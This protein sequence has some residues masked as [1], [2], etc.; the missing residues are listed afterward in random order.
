M[1]HTVYAHVAFPLSPCW[2]VVWTLVL[3][4]TLHTLI[5]VHY[6]FTNGHRMIN[7]YSE[8]L[9]FELAVGRCSSEVCLITTMCIGI[10]LFRQSVFVLRETLTVDLALVSLEDWSRS[11]T[12]PSM[13]RPLQL[14]TYL[15][16]SFVERPISHDQF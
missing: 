8:S 14:D 10:R 4:A 6:S 15:S 7:S 5:A 1:F 12:E 13:P 16:R 9:V 3:I 2:T 11:N